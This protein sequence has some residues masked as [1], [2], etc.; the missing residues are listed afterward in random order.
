[1]DLPNERS[2]HVI[3]TP[4]GG[5]LIIAIVTLVVY[6]VGS[7]VGLYQLSWGFVTGALLILIV[8]WLDD[9]YSV[10]F[11]WRL[12]VH[13]VAAMMLI[14]SNGYVSAISLPDGVQTVNIGWFGA[15]LTFLWIIWLVNAYNFM[16]GIDG[17]AG[18]QALTAGLGW[19]VLGSNWNLPV[20]TMLGGT[21]MFV[22]FAFLFHN[23]PPARIFMGDAGS[24]FL[25]F[26]FAGLPLLERPESKV[27]A[28][29][30]PIAGVLFVWLFVFDS[31]F[32]F[33]R[34]AGRFEKVWQAHR[35]H[36]YQRLVLSTFSHRSTTLIYGLISITISVATI[37]WLSNPSARSSYLIALIVV[38]QSLIIVA[39]CWKRNCLFGKVS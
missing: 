39:L 28:G 23:W 3:P 29:F 7:F 5:G 37:V 22:S 20:G 31:V 14:C 18:L 2:S 25:G 30:L 27:N 10:P 26:V 8:S 17:I 9:V 21:V 11:I 6:F 13:S 36:L 38:T 32:T 16:D 4:R 15:V 33:L 12:L 24:A 35:E 1:M 19:L 34:R